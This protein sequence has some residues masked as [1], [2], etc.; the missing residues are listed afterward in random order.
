MGRKV[1][2]SWNMHKIYTQINGDKF[3]TA[4][5]IVTKYLPNSCHLLTLKWKQISD[6]IYEVRHN[7]YNYVK[8]SKDKST[9]VIDSLL[10]I[11]HK[12]MMFLG[13]EW[14]HSCVKIKYLRTKKPTISQ[15]SCNM[16]RKHAK[17]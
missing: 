12:S 9:P 4:T 5:C 3:T 7:A 6:L 11:C 10:E 14:I 8:D 17:K 2:K 15:L 1:L 16:K 13:C